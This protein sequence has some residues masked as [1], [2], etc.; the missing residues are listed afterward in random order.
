MLACKQIE[1]AA[2]QRNLT[3]DWDVDKLSCL[4]TRRTFNDTLQEVKVC[5]TCFKHVGSRLLAVGM[6]PSRSIFLV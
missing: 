1:E 4:G 3:L 2:K 6:T 5:I